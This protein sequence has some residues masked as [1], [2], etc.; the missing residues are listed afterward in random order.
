MLLKDNGAADLVKQGSDLNKGLRFSKS[1]C[2]VLQIVGKTPLANQADPVVLAK[3]Q[4]SFLQGMPFSCLR[5]A[6]SNCSCPGQYPI[7]EVKMKVNIYCNHSEST[8]YFYLIHLLHTLLNQWKGLQNLPLHRQSTAPREA[9]R[10]WAG[11]N[12]A[13]CLFQKGANSFSLIFHAGPW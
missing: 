6:V 13:A 1:R 3:S 7:V 4:T 12:L 5:R 11:N 8:F 2:N 10:N 9:R